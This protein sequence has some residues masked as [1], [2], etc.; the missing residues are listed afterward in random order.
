ML[1]AALIAGEAV[2]EGFSHINELSV[3]E[4]S[5]RPND[6]VTKYDLASEEI[7]IKKLRKN[8][9]NFKVIAE[10]SSKEVPKNW[11]KGYV[12]AIDPIDGTLNFRYGRKE[13]TISIGLLKD[14]EP[15]AGV[16]Y[17]P[18]RQDLYYAE[19][20]KGAYLNGQPIHVRQHPL[21]KPIV[22]FEL[23]DITDNALY[24]SLRP[25]AAQI[26]QFG[27]SAALDMAHVA[28]GQIDAQVATCLNIWDIA[29]GLI[30]VAEA[31]GIVTE[32]DGGSQN[33]KT[34]YDGCHIVAG[35]KKIVRELLK[36]LPKVTVHDIRFGS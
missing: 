14:G 9:P 11:D 4:K 33:L 15:I 31:G 32:P 1:D 10:E 24:S 8:F 6:I 27:G 21:K 3:E 16:I 34:E 13:F 26:R 25:I 36:S 28:S 22:H 30:I 17:A 12:W 23:N 20:G 18:A 19:K 2:M 29:A 35:D 7:I 5:T